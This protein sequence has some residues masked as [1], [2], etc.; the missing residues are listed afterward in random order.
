MRKEF[1]LGKDIQTIHGSIHYERHRYCCGKCG[2]KEYV[3]DAEMGLKKR[4]TVSPKKEHILAAMATQM[5]YEGAEKFYK[6]LSSQT[7]SSTTIH[8]KTQ[9]IAQKAQEKLIAKQQR[10]QVE[11]EDSKPHISA[12][13]VMIYLRTEGWKEARVGVVYEHNAE[14]GI[15]SNQGYIATLHS[16]EEF[17][18]L[19]YR[20]SNAPKQNKQKDMA[21][22]SD[23]AHWLWDIHRIHFRQAT[24]IVDYYHASSYLWTLAKSFYGEQTEKTKK[25]AE[26]KKEKL[27]KGSM[28][29]L[30]ADILKMVPKTDEQNK[31][32]QSALTYFKN[33]GHK[34]N[35]SEYKK[36]GFH[37]GSGVVESSCKH[38][39][40]QRFKQSGMR[41]SRDGAERLLFLRSL[42]MNGQ[43]QE[44]LEMAA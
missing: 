23:G 15:L 5:T 16:R 44:V 6:E 35:Y 17:G 30:Q 26:A 11:N 21:Y 13:G 22:I 19:L 36:L 2:H 43:W 29:Q 9:Q 37:I 25:W 20:L 31:K 4:A 24:A 34:M 32:W 7:T 40:Q 8:R 3:Y 1:I 18:K 27:Y 38:L 41:W 39:V 42:R 14:E 33:H 28:R 10:N 12:D